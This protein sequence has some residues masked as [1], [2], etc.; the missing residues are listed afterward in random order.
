MQETTATF[1]AGRG[2]SNGSENA[3]VHAAALATSS[4]MTDS[5][6]GQPLFLK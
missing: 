5:G 3:A 4:S 6:V 1:R 2:V